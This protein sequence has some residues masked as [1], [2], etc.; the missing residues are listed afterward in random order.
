MTD[1]VQAQDLL[2]K[3]TQR[4]MVLDNR[5]TSD[6]LC[7]VVSKTDTSITPDRYI[8]THPNVKQL[9]EPTSANL[10]AHNAKLCRAEKYLQEKEDDRARNQ[11]ALDRIELELKKTKAAIKK[12]APKNKRAKLKS[13]DD[14][15]GMFLHIHFPVLCTSTK[16]P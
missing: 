12:V 14:V 10:E 6:Q 1:Y 11:K 8:D 9:L 13:G 5:F 2:G 16:H 4:T 7:F 3:V 15:S